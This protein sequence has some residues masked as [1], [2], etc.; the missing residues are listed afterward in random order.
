[1]SREIGDSRLARTTRAPERRVD[2]TNLQRCSGIGQPLPAFA[3]ARDLTRGTGT[4]R[5]ANNLAAQASTRATSTTAGAVRAHRAFPS[6]TTSI[7]VAAQGTS[8]AV[9][10]AVVRGALL[11]VVKG[12]LARRRL[13]CP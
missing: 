5:R 8:G 12:R 11:D 2:E 7:A 3:S 1:M 9:V 13:D 10:G 4:R 6:A